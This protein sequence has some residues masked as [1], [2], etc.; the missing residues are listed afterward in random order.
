[1]RAAFKL[2]QLVLDTSKLVVIDES[3]SNLALARLYGWGPLAERVYQS[4]RRNWGKNI[5]VLADVSLK[6][7]LMESVVYYEGGTT[8]AIFESWVEQALI[9]NLAAGQVVIMDKLSSHKGKRVRELIEGAEC[10]L[11]YL[12]AYSPDLTPIELVFSKC[13]SVLR[14]LGARSGEKLIEGWEQALSAV[15]AEEIAGMF[16]HCGYPLLPQP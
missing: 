14:K 6:G 8:S 9:P 15:K 2:K 12:P 10:K 1:V 7:I 4:V 13:K 5:T 16:R 3:G 11:E